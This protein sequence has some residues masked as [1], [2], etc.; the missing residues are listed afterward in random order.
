MFTKITLKYSENKYKKFFNHFNNTC[1]GSK[2]PCKIWNYYDIIKN[3]KNY[4][5]FYFINNLTEN[6]NRYLNIN[7]KRAKCFKSLFENV[8]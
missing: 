8:F 5:K 3:N 1:I 2:Y 6:I 4:E 7:L